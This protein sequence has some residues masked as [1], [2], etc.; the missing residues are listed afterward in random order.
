MKDIAK[1]FLVVLS[2]FAD[3]NLTQAQWVRTGLD[4]G[5]VTSFAQI[6]PKLFAATSDFHGVFVSP[7]SGNVWTKIG[8]TSS[9]IQALAVSSDGGGSVNIFVG[10][11]GG[12]FLSTNNGNNW[13]RIDSGFANTDVYALVIS[14]ANLFAGTPDGIYTS[15]DHGGTWTAASSGLTFTW[16]DALAVSPNGPDGDNLYAGTFGGG[17]FLSTDTGA[18]WTARNSSLGNYCIK[19]IVASG[20]SLFIGTWGGGI[21]RSDKNEV[22][23]ATANSG[24]SDL[25]VW[26]LGRSGAILLAGTEAGIFRSSD[27][28]NTW[29]S[30]GLANLLVAAI[31]VSGDY[32]FAGTAEGVWRRPLSDLLTELGD[33]EKEISQR[34]LLH[35]NYPNPFNGTTSIRYELPAKSYVTL[36]VFDLLGR[37]IAELVNAT[38]DIGYKSVQFNSTD[39]PSG[40]YFY[41]L[42]AGTFT[43]TEKLMLM[44]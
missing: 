22:T 25:R 11:Y 26:S 14:G 23:W 39:L 19:S 21:F 41:R 44:K 27:D 4:S 12:I 35:Q 34:F 7:N 13:A 37:E 17:V 15:V 29:T 8:L 38:Q 20:A 36:K 3:S 16:V 10:T 18:N 24:L 5:I 31:T 9:S 40:V 42:N 1:L 2:L 43:Q 6:G 32:V 30:F 33:Q 28:G